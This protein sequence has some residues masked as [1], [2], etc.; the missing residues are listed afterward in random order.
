M[1]EEYVTKEELLEKIRNSYDVFSTLLSSLNEAQLTEPGVNDGWSV[2]DNIAHLSAWQRRQMVYNEAV[3][4]GVESG[5]PTPGM[6]LDEINEMYYRQNKD[7]SLAEVLAEFHE[8]VRQFRESIEALTDEQ[9][10]APVPWLDNRSL[11]AYIASNS[12]EHYKEHIEIIQH[13]LARQSA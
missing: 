5:N 11:I 3:Y 7:R 6:S 9:L 8:S 12:Y 10:N 1:T 13:W 2:K 4:K